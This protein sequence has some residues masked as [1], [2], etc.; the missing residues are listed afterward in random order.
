M[1]A[2]YRYLQL[3]DRLAIADNFGSLDPDI[4]VE[5]QITDQ[6]DTSNEFQGLDL[7]LVWQGGWKKWTLECLLKTAVGNVHQSVNIQGS[8][9]I[10]T[11]ATSPVSSVG[12][13]LALPTNIGSY[14]RDQVALLPELGVNLGYQV[15][16]HLRLTAGYTFLYLGSVVRPGDQIDL[17]VNPDQLAPPIVPLVGAPR[18]EFAFQEVDFWVQGLTLGVEGRW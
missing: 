14:G 1:L 9:V 7:G 5:Y 3:K 2:G 16:P 8:T 11:G 4:P 17:D 6:F 15:L 12:G 18:P 13:L 10:T